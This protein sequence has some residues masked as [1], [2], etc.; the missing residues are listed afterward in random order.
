MVIRFALVR[1]DVRCNRGHAWCCKK[2]YEEAMT[3][4]NEAIR[5]DPQSAVSYYNRGLV[6]SKRGDAGRA[7]DD[8]DQADWLDPRLTEG[9]AV[10]NLF[11]ADEWRAV[12]RASART[13]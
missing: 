6:W 9:S 11:W 13:E 12:A 4:L 7:Q 2:D 3:D 10:N 1:I 5:L 8:W